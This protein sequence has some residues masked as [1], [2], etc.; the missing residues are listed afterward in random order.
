MN[1]S[2]KELET[3]IKILVYEDPRI[4]E[5]KLRHILTKKP[6]N[7]NIQCNTILN[8]CKDEGW[9]S[10]DIEELNNI[11]EAL[12]LELKSKKNGEISFILDEVLPSLEAGRLSG[13]SKKLLSKAMGL[14][15][16]IIK[17]DLSGNLLI[18][19]GYGYKPISD[20]MY[21]Y[22][23]NELIGNNYNL[24]LVQSQNISGY[25]AR[26]QTPDKELIIFK[27]GI[28]NKKQFIEK[29]TKAVYS[30]YQTSFNWNP[31]AKGDHIL[32][33]LKEMLG[34]QIDDF[35]KFIGY[36]FTPGNPNQVIGF[37][38]GKKGAGKSTLA[39]IIQTIIPRYS[40]VSLQSIAKEDFHVPSLYCKSINIV[41]DT[42]TTP[43]HD[44]APINTLSSGGSIR[45]NAKNKEP[46]EA[47]PDTLPKCLIIG[48]AAPLIRDPS[49]AIYD[50]VIIF[51]TISNYRHNENEIIDFGSTLT[52]EDYE[53]LLYNAI[54]KFRKS[55]KT[56]RGGGKKVM[57]RY[58]LLSNPLKFVINKTYFLDV[59]HTNITPTHDVIN[60]LIVN[61]K[62]L[63]DAKKL[64]TMPKINPKTIKPLLE[65][66]GAIYDGGKDEDGKFIR[67]YRYLTFKESFQN[68][69][70]YQ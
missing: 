27:N 12:P 35:L 54:T 5:H 37:L 40:N 26:Y 47:T 33:A 39:K 4:N 66:L 61:S 69:L 53:W 67:G 48:N 24:T 38:I 20:F 57:E 23:L 70:K 15:Y 42:L 49:E 1:Y 46:F 68:K 3:F 45:I 65:E 36:C 50:R 52:D 6:E 9:K 19:E 30:I 11:N 13:R 14:K 25:E 43:I 21:H 18:K 10:E 16:D 31:K 28:L 59:D 32:P 17:D 58:E 41:D 55:P 56:L 64:K 2:V 62:K 51:E 22:L 60:D 29:P 8:N 63:I 44:V 7:I 34:D